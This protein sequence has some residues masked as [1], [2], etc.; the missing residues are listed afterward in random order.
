[1]SRTI[2]KM[3]PS[4]QFLEEAI[5]V[6][7]TSKDYG[8]DMDY[9]LANLASATGASFAP[10]LLGKPLSVAEGM[11]S[12]STREIDLDKEI[13]NYPFDSKVLMMA[14]MRLSRNGMILPGTWKSDFYKSKIGLFGED[15]SIRKTLSEPGTAAAYFESMFNFFKLRRETRVMPKNI[16]DE[17]RLK[18]EIDKHADVNEIGMGILSMAQAYARF[19][20]DP[21]SFYSMFNKPLKNKFII[22]EFGKTE[23]GLDMD[24]DVTMPNDMFRLEAKML[25]EYKYE[26][27]GEI[28]E[29]INDAMSYSPDGKEVYGEEQINEFKLKLKNAIDEINS[30][31][32]GAEK[33]YQADFVAN[34]ADIMVREMYNRGVLSE[35]DIKKLKEK[36]IDDS[37]FESPDIPKWGIDMYEVGNLN[38]S[39]PEVYNSNTEEED[40]DLSYLDKPL[41]MPD[42]DTKDSEVLS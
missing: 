8:K 18:H 22:T 36:G 30:L 23:E 33:D 10:S 37:V 42:I 7:S 27:A 14:H 3:T 26:K 20:G 25:G 5:Q 24:T 17:R 2:F 19:G 1:M 28:K 4:A 35:N 31:L 41:Y 32:D 9:L 13:A 12:Q 34:R 11:K 21:S 6:L 15:L 38:F 39:D 40:E 16:K 29:I